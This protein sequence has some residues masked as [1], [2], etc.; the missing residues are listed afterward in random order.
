MKGAAIMSGL[1][2]DHRGSLASNLKTRE[3]DE[4]RVIRMPVV[5][6]IDRRFAWEK[7]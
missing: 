6:F 1:D 2:R 4:G 3:E 5:G 7:V